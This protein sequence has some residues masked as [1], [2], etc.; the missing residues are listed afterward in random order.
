MPR[1]NGRVY[2][3]QMS[4]HISTIILKEI[5]DSRLV[6]LESAVAEQSIKTEVR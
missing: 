5:R 4:C 2:T 1:T 3:G 6:N